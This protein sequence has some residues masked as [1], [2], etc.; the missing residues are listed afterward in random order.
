MA[1]AI[2]DSLFRGFNASGINYSHWRNSENIK[3]ALNGDRELDVFFDEDQKQSV[4]EILKKN[5]FHLFEHAWYRRFKGK[6]D[7]IGFDKESGKI[8]H[9]YA[10]FNLYKRTGSVKKYHLP[11]KDLILEH[12]VFNDRLNMYVSIPEIDYLLL[13]IRTAFAFNSSNHKANQQL[14]EK[15]QVTASKLHSQIDENKLLVISLQALDAD[16]TEGINETRKQDSFDTR[17][18]IRLKKLFKQH[19]TPQR[20]INTKKTVYL[21][22]IVG[23]KNLQAQFVKSIGFKVAKPKKRLPH[24]G[25]V[26]S[27]MGSDGAGKSTQTKEVVAELSKKSEV[28]FMYMG[29]GDGPRSLHRRIIGSVFGLSSRVISP[30]KW[31]PDGTAK[32]RT[33]RTNTTQKGFVKQFILS[34]RPLSLAIEKKRRLKQI[35]KAR[36]RGAI[37]IC[38]RYP[39]TTTIGYNDG[40]NLYKYITSSNKLFSYLAKYEYSCYD[41]ANEIHPDVAIKLLG[42]L[43]VLHS[44]RPGMTIEELNKKQTGIQE[45]KFGDS[46][47]VITLDIDRPIHRIK[48]D[49][50]DALS[51]QIYDLNKFA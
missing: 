24:K 49:I 45:L 17:V 2:V 32:K 33:K 38:D 14:I 5:N 44:R 34:L 46:T 41:L 16:I 35:E 6:E 18:F 51:M 8:V 30:E 10:H 1:L 37:I 21:H 13:V 48:G 47:K 50:L 7:Y 27:L 42:P 22:L 40:P 20:V 31:N 9:I 26:I 43:E 11:W 36:K 4:I 25:V 23:Y 29:A 19:F 39:Q 15:F 28:L 3:L 12:R